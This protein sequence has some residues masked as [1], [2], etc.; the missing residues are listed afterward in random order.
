[1]KKIILILL[2]FIYGH[3]DIIKTIEILKKIEK[4]QYDFKKI[5]KYNAFEPNT[6]FLESIIINNK[7]SQII[8]IKAIFNK[9]V[10]INNS[11][12]K[13]GDTVNG[14]KIIKIIDNKIVLKKNNKLL[15]LSPKSQLIKVTK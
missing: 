1:M 13:I 4:Y 2:F 15:I 8:K 11:W 10:Y 7:T 12:Y 5:E 9:K 6:N 14:Y 3:S